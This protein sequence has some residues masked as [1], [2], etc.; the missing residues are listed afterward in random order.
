MEG[1]ELPSLDQKTFQTTD[2]SD[3]KPQTP[4]LKGSLPDGARLGMPIAIS[5]CVKRVLPR[6]LRR[7]AAPH[8]LTPQEILRWEGA[9]QYL[10]DQGFECWWAVVGDDA[11]DLDNWQARRVHDDVKNRIGILQSRAQLPRYCIEVLE[12]TGGLHSNLIFPGNRW[13]GSHLQQAFPQYLARSG[14]QQVNYPDRTFRDYL[15]KERTPQAAFALGLPRKKGSY[16]LDGGG[17]RVRLSEALKADA[18]A[19]GRIEPWQPTHARRKPAAQD[20]RTTNSGRRRAPITVE[21]VPKSGLKEADQLSLW[22]EH[23]RPVVRLKA[24]AGGIAPPTVAMELEHLRRRRGLTQ[25][26]LGKLVGLSQP[27]IANAV[28]GRFGLSRH[29]AARIREL[30][31]A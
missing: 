11:L 6:T 15:I 21:Q 4:D 13:I 12:V 5:S 16:P 2:D 20:L 27:Q 17:D 3:H 9:L 1:M 28:H 31:A 7:T 8:G 10:R 30:L 18:I 25:R 23:D 14:V 22:P 24:Y 29:A 19:A 26:A